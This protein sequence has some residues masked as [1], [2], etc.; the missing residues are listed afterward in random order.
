MEREQAL[1]LDAIGNIYNDLGDKDKCSEFFIRELRIYE[2]TK[3]PVGMAQAMSRIGVLYTDHKKY[4][5]TLEYLERSLDLTR[6]HMTWK[7]M[8]SLATGSSG[9]AAV[10]N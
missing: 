9:K 7:F 6:N 3:D 5:K 4:S 1:S 2:N 10:L 8:I